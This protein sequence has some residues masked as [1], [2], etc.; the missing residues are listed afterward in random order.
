MSIIRNAREERKSEQDSNGRR[1][2]RRTRQQRKKEKEKV[3]KSRSPSPGAS[4]GS[5]TVGTVT[6]ITRDREITETRSREIQKDKE[7]ADTCERQG[8]SDT[9]GTGRESEK[10]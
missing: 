7:M 4:K 8:K 9:K 1:R 6:L 10:K 2:M 5:T 3:G